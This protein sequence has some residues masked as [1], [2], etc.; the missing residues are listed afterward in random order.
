MV[1]FDAQ[2]RV[3]DANPLYLALIGYALP[4]IQGQAHDRLM[5][6]GRSGDPDFQQLWER[7]Q[8]GEAQRAEIERIDRQGRSVWMQ[9]HYTPLLDDDGKLWRV[10]KMA[11]DITAQKERSLDDQYTL[12]AIWQSRGVVEYDLQGRVLC[13]NERFCELLGHSQDTLL[14]KQ[15]TDLLDPV[16]AESVVYRKFWSELAA[17]RQQSVHLKRVGASGQEVWTQSN[18]YPVPDAH[19]RLVKIV[20]ISGD[21]TEQVRSQQ[22]LKLLETCVA[23][24]NDMVQITEVDVDG[25]NHPKLVFVNDT[26]T[27]RT[28]Y[29]R[30]EVLGRSPRILQG[31]ATQRRELDRIRSALKRWQPVRAELINYTKSGEMF[32]V[33]LDIN[34]IA[35]GDGWFTHWVAVSRDISQRKQAEAQIQKL[36]FYDELTELPNRRLLQDRLEHAL[37]TTSRSAEQAALL[38]IDLDDFKTFNDAQRTP[39]RRRGVAPGRPSAGR[40]AARFGHRGPRRWRRVHRAAGK[41]PC[42]GRG[43][44]PAGRGHRTQA[45]RFAGAALPGRWRIAPHH[46]QHR[47]C[48]VQRPQRHRRRRAQNA[49]RWRCTRPR[50]PA[51]TPCNSSIRRCRSDWPPAQASKPI[52]ARLSSATSS[53]CTTSR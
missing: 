46:G 5:P 47:H 35:N 17:G 6:P 2:G 9:A 4:E 32:W 33:E 38:C 1:E 42:V 48:G 20:E 24:L 25:E 30:Q 22:Q 8:A 15:A 13:V 34:P 45:A 3:V 21:I 26:F 27:R 10:L 41:H 53:R 39:R 14:T 23:R 43:S 50:L 7:L 28:G 36:A 18:C 49:H 11:L 16:F 52:C 29:T 19:G 31:P 40:W 12:N 51:A 37:G 44:R